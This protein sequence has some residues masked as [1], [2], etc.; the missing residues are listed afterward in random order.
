V[1]HNPWRRPCTISASRAYDEHDGVNRQGD[2]RP[3]IARWY[4]STARTSRDAGGGATCSA[5]IVAHRCFFTGVD[6]HV[7]DLVAQFF[8]RLFECR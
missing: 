1:S 6:Q 7:R 5:V 3:C 8:E 4:Q 2:G